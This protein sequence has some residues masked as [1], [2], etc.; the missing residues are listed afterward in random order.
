MRSTYNLIIGLMFGII[1]GTTLG[2]LVLIINRKSTCTTLSSGMTETAEVDN[3]MAY[4]L[5]K[6]K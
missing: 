5:E 2:Q 1:I 4:C 6:L 3:F